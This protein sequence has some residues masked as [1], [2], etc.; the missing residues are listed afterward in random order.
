MFICFFIKPHSF[1]KYTQKFYLR[2]EHISIMMLVIS[3]NL[4]KIYPI[5]KHI[6]ID[7]YNTF[8]YTN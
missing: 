8:T 3:K 7:T 2:L 5:V 6:I 4:I 1:F